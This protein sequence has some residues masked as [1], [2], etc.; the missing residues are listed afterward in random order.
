MTEASE[1][2]WLERFRKEEAFRLGRD[3]DQEGYRA[4]DPAMRYVR[5]G[6]G[7]ANC[8]VTGLLPLRHHLAA[9]FQ[10]IV[11]LGFAERF[12][13]ISRHEDP[14]PGVTYALQMAGGIQDVICNPSLVHDSDD[15]LYCE[16]VAHYEDES[17]E[18]ASKYTA[19]LIIFNFAWSAYEAAIETSARGETV[20][21]TLPVHARRLFQA[22]GDRASQIR[23]LDQSYNYARHMCER[24]A[25][26][27]DQFARTI[28]K[29]GLTGPAAAAEMVRVFRNYIVHGDDPLPADSVLPCYRFY[30]VTRVVLLLIQH[31]IWRKVTRPS[32]PVLLSANREEVGRE[33]ATLFLRHL[34]YADVQWRTMIPKRSRYGFSTTRRFLG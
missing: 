13:W 3:L 2:D 14:W 12:S 29:H 10:A 16:T 5:C 26:L 1:K 22:E 7:Q 27:K 25:L 20:K 4:I 32:R 17:Q 6:C 8:W 24:Q 19:A 33:P 21:E 18:L 34:H 30:A 9:L 31:L 15:A 11:A 28:T 23:A